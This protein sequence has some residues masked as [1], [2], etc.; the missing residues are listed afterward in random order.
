MGPIWLCRLLAATRPL[1][2]HLKS[3]IQPLRTNLWKVGTNFPA[4]V[5]IVMNEFGRTDRQRSRR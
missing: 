3:P 4:L 1:A 5:Y 2:A